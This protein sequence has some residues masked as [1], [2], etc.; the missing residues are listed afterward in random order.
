MPA[1]RCRAASATGSLLF[2]RYRRAFTLIEMLVVIF[3]ILAISALT[4]SVAVPPV[5]ERRLREAARNVN[6]MLAGAQGRAIETRRPY[7]VMIVPDAS[8]RFVSLTLHYA[9]VPPPYAG[10]SLNSTCQIARVQ[11]PPGGFPAGWYVF[12]GDTF[13][14]GQTAATDLVQPGDLIQFNHQGHF[15]QIT[16]VDRTRGRW[17][18]TDLGSTVRIRSPGV[19]VPYRVI[20]QPVPSAAPPLTLPESTCLDLENCGFESPFAA[21]F[22]GPNRTTIL[23]SP[24][25]TVLGVVQTGVGMTTVNGPIFLLVGRRANVFQSGARGLTNRTDLTTLWVT[26]NHVTGLVTTV[27]NAA[28]NDPRFYARRAQAKGGRK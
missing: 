21:D 7:G 25:G 27:E 11:N 1:A 22:R 4:I 24:N 17:R 3:V 20:R 15:Y 8:D 13:W 5:E 2:S 19:P 12:V 18:I 23:F 14:L 26:V 6:A 28:G 16:H 9:E 10:D